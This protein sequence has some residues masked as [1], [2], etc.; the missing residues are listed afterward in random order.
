MALKVTEVAGGGDVNKINLRPVA[1]RNNERSASPAGIADACL[2]RIASATKTGRRPRYLTRGNGSSLGRYCNIEMRLSYL[3]PG[4]TARAWQPTLASFSAAAAGGCSHNRKHRSTAPRPLMR[5]GRGPRGP[6]GDGARG[7]PHY[8][9][10]YVARVATLRFQCITVTANTTMIAALRE[11]MTARGT[12]S[13][14]YFI[15]TPTL[16]CFR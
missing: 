15:A 11:P 1:A 6:G 13:L 10:A 2:A 14:R 16:R 3:L 12:I 9:A 5:R 4:A 8:S 7:G